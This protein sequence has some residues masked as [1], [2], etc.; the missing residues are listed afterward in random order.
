MTADGR[1]LVAV[2]EAGGAVTLAIDPVSG[3]SRR[4]GGLA[5][6]ERPMT[7]PF[8]AAGLEVPAD[9]VPVS[10]LNGDPR[11]FS[12]ATSEVLP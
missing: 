3:D 10:G 1:Q 4:I 8:A 11:A 6:G 9:A 7:E 2:A 5:P 12:P